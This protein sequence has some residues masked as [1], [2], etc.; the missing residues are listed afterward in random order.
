VA[1]PGEPAARD[2]GTANTQRHRSVADRTGRLRARRG[3][4][5]QPTPRAASRFADFPISI[6][7]RV[8]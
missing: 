2:A 4:P 1:K 7:L 5:S 8:T 3:R 6:R